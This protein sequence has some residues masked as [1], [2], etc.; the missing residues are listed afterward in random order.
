MGVHSDYKSFSN[1]DLKGGSEIS[2]IEAPDEITVPGLPGYICIGAC[3]M[4]IS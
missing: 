1:V 3:C 4:S 2:S